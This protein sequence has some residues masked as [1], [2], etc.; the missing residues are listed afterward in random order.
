MRNKVFAWFALNFVVFTTLII[1][2]IP[3]WLIRPFTPQ[4]SRDLAVSLAL[5]SWSPVLTVAAAIIS[6]VIAFWL[7]QN[8]RHFYSKVVLIA[9]L[10]LVLVCVWFARQ[11]HFEWMFNPLA[12]L[13]YAKADE[14]DFVAD[15]DMVLAVNLNG[16]AAA[17]PIR[18]MAYHHIA[19]DVVGGSPITAT[20]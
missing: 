2:A 12:N 3:V 19:Q 6:F 16:E 17:Y 20:Y 1:V 4:S 9:P 13:T 7:W 8:L 14:T 15:D 10:A 5:K 18:Q 11:N